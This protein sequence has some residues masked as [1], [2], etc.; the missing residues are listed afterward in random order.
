MKN[1][2]DRFPAWADSA[3]HNLAAVL[4]QPELTPEQTWT[5]AVASAMA[6]CSPAL[7]KAV[8]QAAVGRLGESQLDSA[9]KAYVL[10]ATNNVFYR[11]RHRL[12]RSEIMDIPARLRLS[13]ARA[14]GG[15]ETAFELACVA[16]S[17]IHDCETCLRYHEQKARDKGARLEAVVAAARLAAAFHAAAGVL[18]SL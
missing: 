12:R 7:L 3:R 18:E 17:A 10:M 1:V 15:D 9:R 11:F 16:V 8:E 6:C 4:E 13:D 14:H 5:V 2:L